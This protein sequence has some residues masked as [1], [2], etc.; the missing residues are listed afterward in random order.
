[1]DISDDCFHVLEEKQDSPVVSHEEIA[2]SADENLT[3][4]TDSALT[5]FSQELS[6]IPSIEAQITF[7]LEQM[8][9]ALEN[10]ANLKLFWSIRKHCLPL[11]QQVE[12][13]GQRADLWSRYIDLTKEGR[14]V[15]SLQD[16]EGAFVIGQIELAISCLEN[17][18]AN[19]VNEDPISVQQEELPACL[20]IQT[21]EKRREFY[22]KL[23]LSLVWLSNFSTRIIDLRKELMNVG[24]RM[25]L[26]SKF[27]QRLSALGNQ[28]FPKRKE[29]IEQVSAAF[30][31]DVECFVAKY[32]SHNNKN[33]LKR[34]VFFLRKEIKNLQ[35]AAK[36]LAISSDI[37]SSTRLQ[38]SKCWDQLKGLE[39]EI[40]QEQSR[41]KVVSTENS[42]EVRE[43]LSQLSQLLEEGKDLVK[44]RK[45]LDGISKR[46]RSLDLTHEDVVALKGELQGVFD[47]L[48]EKQEVEDKRLQ[49]QAAR[50]RQIQQE[51]I[52]ELNE[53][54]EAFSEKCLSGNITNESRSEW[55]EL[56]HKLTKATYL[57]ASEKFPLENRLN[58]ILQYIISFLEEQLLSS[59]HADEKLV[60]MRQVLA[61]RQERRKELKHKLEYDKKLLGSSGLDFDLAMQYSALV[62]QDKRAL[63]ELDE[64][65][66]E[67]KQQIQQLSS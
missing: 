44:L 55:G 23:H 60:H 11:F 7:S 40:R 4:A 5:A 8:E 14:R 31:E 15:R 56:K 28:V 61:Q 27:F 29:L 2:P 45:E 20:E 10:N 49:E 41:L 62:E 48:K 13:S 47:K 65:I 18:V 66:V 35:Q 19:F 43:R 21:L 1:M 36:Y 59:A 50:N 54:I 25:R 64:A 17:D 38:L 9:K 37:F 30:A 16:E 12:N 33:S 34:F 26:K 24:M 67:L 39:K 46:M 6:Q 57:T 52:K 22:Q 32:F 51:A 63:E 3:I 53:K 42:K 58:A